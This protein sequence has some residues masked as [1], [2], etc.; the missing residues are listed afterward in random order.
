MRNYVFHLFF[1]RVEGG[2]LFDKVVSISQYD[3]L[4]FPFKFFVGLKVESCLIKLS[5]LVSMRNYV[6]HLI[7][8]RVEGG[9]LFD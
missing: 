3:E 8:C 5:V 7:L 9:E 4:C 6:F 1:C 2:E